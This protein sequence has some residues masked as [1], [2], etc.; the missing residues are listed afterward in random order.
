MSRRA[1]S[2]EA[3]LETAYGI[4]GARGLASL[5]IR[6]L[7][8]EGGVAVGTVYNYFPAKE[9]LTA[10]V[11]QRYFDRACRDLCHP[12]PGERF[13]DYA[14]RTFAS[15]SEAYA[16]FRTRWLAGIEGLPETERAAI[17]RRQ[18][19]VLD[20]IER[21]LRAAFRNDPAIDPTRLAPGVNGATVCRFVLANIV[22]A[23][24]EQR[25]S[26]DVL[27]CLVERTLYASGP[28]EGGLRRDGRNTAAK[29]PLDTDAAHEHR[30]V[31]V[32]VGNAQDGVRP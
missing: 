16:A 17:R 10:A 3:L 22:D 30:L 5:S 1:T 19:A 8:C 25:T 14:R 6:A 32:Q 31:D 4:A 29:R 24:R 12:A 23:L 15:M 21:S 9:D 20:Q 13:A 28:D 7:A 11:A 18:G 2:R 27:F 26:C